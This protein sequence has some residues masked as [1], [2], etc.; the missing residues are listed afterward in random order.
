MISK[1]GNRSDR[2]EGS[3]YSDD[4]LFFLDDYFN[5]MPYTPNCTLQLTPDPAYK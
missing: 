3:E 2:N 1:E 4:D 5:N